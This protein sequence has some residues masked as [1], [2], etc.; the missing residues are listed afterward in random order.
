MSQERTHWKELTNPKY[1]GAFEF[2]P[3]E[4]RVVQIVSVQKE[5]VVG[6]GGKEQELIVAQ[7]RDPMDTKKVVKPMILNATNCKAL[8]KRTKSGIIQ[9]WA[10]VKITLYVDPKVRFGKDIVEG[11]R[12]KSEAPPLPE[13]SKDGQ[14]AAKWA[15]AV[16]SLKTGQCT[17]G[18]IEAQYRLS[19]ENRELLIAEAAE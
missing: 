15:G 5:M 6:D 1:I 19:P 12:I 16:S 18:Q 2:A 3:G 10:G 14:F 17:I 7:L 4:E 11:L 9:D 8:T 13:L